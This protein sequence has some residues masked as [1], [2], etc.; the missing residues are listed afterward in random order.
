MKSRYFVIAFCLLIACNSSQEADDNLTTDK[1]DDKPVEEPVRTGLD[2]VNLPEGF[3]ISEFAEVENARSLALSPSGVVYVGNRQADKVYA[4]KDTNG[5]GKAEEKY[6][7]AEGLNSPNGVAFKDGDLYVAEISRILRFNDIESKLDNPG[8]Y[9]VVYDDYPTEGHHGWKYIAFGP[10]G[11]LYVPVGAP[12]NI[13]KS[14]DPV[15]ASI[16]RINTDGTGREIVAEGVRNTVGFDWHPDTKNLWFTDNGRD[17]MGDNIPPCELNRVTQKGQ[18]FGYPFCHGGDIA[19]PEFGSERHCNEF[20]KP[21]WNFAAHTAPLGMKF[22]T[23]TMFPEEYKGDIIVAQ[24]GSWNRSS[25]IGYRLMRLKVEGS[26]VAEAE[27]FADGWLNERAQEAWGRPV[28]VLQ[29]TDGSL[30]VSDDQAGKIYR[31]TYEK[32]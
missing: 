32:Q 17:M 2:R 19:D 12:C 14:D 13:C 16:T 25:K 9:E 10:D 30:L 8:N 27:V 23:G 22:Y 11:K 7:I 3:Q 1:P 18:H 28:D 31:I 24:H 15:F 5:D 20:K 6:I 21:V 26:G 4:L 29:I